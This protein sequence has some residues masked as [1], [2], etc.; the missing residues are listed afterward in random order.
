MAKHILFYA[1]NG[2][3][4]G[5][6]TRTL[7]IAR[8][9]VKLDSDISPYFFTSSDAAQVISEHGFLYTKV[10]S[11]TLLKLNGGS[12]WQLQIQYQMTLLERIQA[13]RP[14][15]LVVDTF[16]LGS[17]D[18]LSGVLNL[19][20]KAMKKVF[21]HREQ[22]PE[23]MTN[24]RMRLQNFYDLVI[25]PHNEGAARIPVPERV[26]LE[27][28]GNIMI[29]T[30]DELFSREKA[31]K[32]MRVPGNKKIILVNFG[33][34]GDASTIQNYEAV[35]KTLAPYSDYFHFVVPEAPLS[36]YKLE[37][38]ENASTIKY[39]PLVELMQGFDCAISAAGYNTFHELLYAGVPTIFVPKMRGYDDQEQ[40]A[41]NATYADAAIM[42]YEEML[43]NQ[44]ILASSINQ[45]L[46]YPRISENAQ[47][48]VPKNGAEVA[49][50][51][52]L[53]IL[54]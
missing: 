7:S 18:D 37:L 38:P 21:I 20:R 51:K 15:G 5:H 35:F 48:F 11:K 14:K 45:L 31:R 40:R 54:E 23:K 39:Y 29:R 50:N 10:P 16:P 41:R 8:Q 52:I 33:G 44:D 30:K 13:L 43:P 36:R 12:Y 2:L 49:A 27:W 1:V 22:R 53:E 17:V 32:I 46:D 3:G 34:G 4:L 24:R 6:V 25:A 26:D 9:L 42:L 47:S 19:K 28:A